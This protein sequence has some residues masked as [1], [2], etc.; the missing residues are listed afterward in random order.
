VDG[1][2]TGLGAEDEAFDA[3]DI[4]EVELGNALITFVSEVVRP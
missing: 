3:D 1:D 4:A 2:F